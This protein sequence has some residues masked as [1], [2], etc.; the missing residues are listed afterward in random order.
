[1]D[2]E[3]VKLGM[4]DKEMADYIR[5]NLIGEASRDIPADHIDKFLS[6]DKAYL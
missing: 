4:A 2:I 5:E 6:D 3:V 1:M